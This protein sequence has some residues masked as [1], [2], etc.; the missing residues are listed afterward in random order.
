LHNQKIYLLNY[1]S[2][3]AVLRMVS[4]KNRHSFLNLFVVLV[5][6]FYRNQTPNFI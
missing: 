4:L 3:R 1:R 2:V 5:N 6:G